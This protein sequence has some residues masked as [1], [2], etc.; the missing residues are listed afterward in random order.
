MCSSVELLTILLSIPKSCDGTK[1]Y[2]SVGSNAEPFQF[3][4]PVHPGKITRS[5]GPYCANGPPVIAPPSSARRSRQYFSCSG[6]IVATSSGE[7]VIRASG[8]GLTG[9]G[10]VGQ[11]SSPGSGLSDATGRSSTPKIGWPVTRLK[12]NSSPCFVYWATAGI[13][14]PPRL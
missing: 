4:P 8:G 12:M 2:P 3:P 5:F 9:N 14:W 13:V 10:C 1:R 6:V 11:Y 7:N